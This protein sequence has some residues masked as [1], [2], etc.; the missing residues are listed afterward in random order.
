MLANILPRE[1]RFSRHPLKSVLAGLWSILME[2]GSGW[3]RWASVR[4]VPSWC[5]A[6]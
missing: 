5:R 2:L 1:K 4:P 3:L 6:N